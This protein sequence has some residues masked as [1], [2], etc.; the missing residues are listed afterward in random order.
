MQF[1]GAT[2]HAILE[3][4]DDDSAVIG[5]FFGVTFDEAVVHEA[6]KAVM[7]AGT[8]E[9]QQV[10]AQQRQLFLLAENPN[11]A[12]DRALVRALGASRNGTLVVH[13]HNSSWWPSRRRRI[14]RP[15]ILCIA[16]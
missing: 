8:I 15:S 5:A 13:S 10:I 3:I 2:H 12:L 7:A 4:G 14:P 1:G 11:G 16:I 6:M 9:P